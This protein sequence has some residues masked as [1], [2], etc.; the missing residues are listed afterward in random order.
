MPNLKLIHSDGVTFCPLKDLLA[1]SGIASLHL[2]V[3]AETAGMAEEASFAK[4][5]D[6]ALFVNTS[7]GELV[8][9]DELI[10][11]DIRAVTEGRKPDR[12]VN[13]VLRQGEAAGL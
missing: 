12:M 4:M 1:L 8:D 5:K 3:T 9:D 13:S 2:P 10:A 6:G 11:E 7:R